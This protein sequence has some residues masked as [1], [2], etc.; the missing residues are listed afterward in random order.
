MDLENPYAIST[1]AAMVTLTPGTVSADITPDR[2]WLLVHALDVAD[3]AAL[4]ADI[5]QRYERPLAEI[6][7]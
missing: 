6:L 1:L 2:R 3:E 4:I 7:P 5:K